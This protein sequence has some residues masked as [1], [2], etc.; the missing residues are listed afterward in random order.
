MSYKPINR[1]LKTEAVTVSKS[2]EHN[3]ILTPFVVNLS[4]HLL[5]NCYIICEI[6]AREGAE[7]FA[8]IHAL[9]Q[10]NERG[11]LGAEYFCRALYSL[12][13]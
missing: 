3:V 7:S 5:S 13:P 11:A 9:S 10:E 1:S 4:Y 8:L 2:T 6:D 12:H